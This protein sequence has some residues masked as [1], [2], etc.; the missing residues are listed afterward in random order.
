MKR[1][2]FIIAAWL[3]L[4][5]PTLLIGGVALRLLQHEQ[6]RLAGAAVAAAGERARATAES[7]ALAVAEVRDGLLVTLRT[8]PQENLVDRLDAWRLENPLIRNVFIW[9][10]EGGLS[11]P[12]PRQPV[13][14][15]EA[16]FI[17]RYDSLFTGRM[18]WN[19][20]APDPGP[21]PVVDVAKSLF[22]TRRELREL[23][24]SKL[25][26]ADDAEPSV[27][28]SLPSVGAGGWI[29]WFWENRFY[30]LGWVES[31]DNQ[32]R[33]GVEIETMALFSRLSGTLPAVPPAGEV[34]ALVDGNGKNFYQSGAEAITAETPMLVSVSVGP[35]L[36]HWQVAVYAPQGGPGH[37]EGNSFL[38]LSTLVVGAFVAAILFGGSLLLWQA[39]RNLTDARRKTSFVANVS[40]EL[41][42]PLTTIRMYAELLDEGRI[43][44]ELKR[45]RYLQVIVDESQRLSRLVGNVL[46]FGRLEQGRKSYSLSEFDLG[47]ILDGVLDFQAVRIE[48]A[49]MTLVRRIPGEICVVHAD[50]DAFEQAVLNLID[51]AL[52]YAAGCPELEVELVQDGKACRVR[53]LD[54]GPGVPSTQRRRIFEKFYR[55]DDSLTTRQQGS[56][57]GLSIARRLLRDMGGDLTCSEREGGGCCFEILLPCE[58]KAEG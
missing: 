41:K 29:P 23:T 30:L 10:T 8:L 40:H 56:G 28:A 22:S 18:S 15:E 54:R 38:I 5:V 35:A 49:G 14:D 34:Y 25:T 58:R 32:R 43:A 17:R 19:P 9:G 42:T 3:L 6:E 31:P 20:P 33:Y 16:G 45:R 2:G 44:D 24:Q 46:D 52:K 12:D 47:E 1:T 39:W 21:A 55:V 4:L 53:V 36:P 27:A 26:V 13:S 48:G 11:L 7:I 57:L 50:R 37:A 51:N